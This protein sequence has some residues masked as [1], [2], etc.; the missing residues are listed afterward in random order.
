MR[1]QAEGP[2]DSGTPRQREAGEKQ[3]EGIRDGERD[4]DR[5][6]KRWREKVRHRRQERD[7]GDKRVGHQDTRRQ[8]ARKG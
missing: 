4:G 2:A 8:T 6:R 5:D 7:G 3:T 1:V